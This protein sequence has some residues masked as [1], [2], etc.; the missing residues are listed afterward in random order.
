MD[1]YKKKI[2]NTNFVLSKHMLRNLL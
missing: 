1:V 2:A